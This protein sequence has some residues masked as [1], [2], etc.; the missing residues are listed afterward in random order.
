MHIYERE[1]ERKESVC[2]EPFEGETVGVFRDRGTRRPAGV[3]AISLD[4]LGS[5]SKF[6]AT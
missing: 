5:T 4:C 2:F 3:K 6:F 1:I